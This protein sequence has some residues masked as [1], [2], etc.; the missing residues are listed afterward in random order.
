MDVTYYS[1]DFLS[2]R[3]EPTEL[4]LRGVSLAGGLGDDAGRFSA[5]ID[6]QRLITIGVASSF[7]EALDLVAVGR[8]SIV[9]A[10]EFVVPG[11]GSQG[12]VPLS[13]WQIT[14]V[15]RSSNSP[16][17]QIEGREFGGYLADNVVTADWRRQRGV[18]PVERACTMVRNLMTSGQIIKATIPGAT[19]TLRTDFDAVYGGV[20]Y[21]D[22]VRELAGAGFE[23]TWR[24]GLSGDFVTRTMEIGIPQIAYST[25]LVLE[26]VGPGVTPLGGI[27]LMQEDSTS[28][29]VW[30]MW[31]F[32]SGSGVVQK[33]RRFTDD[34]NR[35]AG[36]PRFSRVMSSR[37]A[38]TTTVLDRE[39]KR[40]VADIR[41]T[42]RRWS[43]VVH[44]DALATGMPR[45]G[46][47]YHLRVDPSPA[48]PNGLAARVRVASW[49]W[50]QP[51]PGDIET[52][53]LGL[54]E[55]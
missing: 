41:R 19:S 6:L 31:G 49:S 28:S 44:A 18:D 12:D 36:M 39:L 37:D 29:M 10:R 15:K 25:G 11:A 5:S 38:T 35:P 1:A 13:E 24:T 53:S 9:A 26:F 7:A 43:A 30:D 16:V 23:W 21:A 27:E 52:V 40:A 14:D 17:V 34:E 55:A 4:D 33:V 32:G 46:D 20:T 8:R 54:E 22:M 42:A 45:A 2:G 51:G 47:L 50:R 48:F 3:R